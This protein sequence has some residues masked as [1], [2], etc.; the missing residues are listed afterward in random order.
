MAKRQEDT[1]FDVRVLDT[2]SAHL[3][4]N[5]WTLAVA[6]SVTSG[7]LQLAFSQTEGATDFF[8]GGVTA[9]HPGIKCRLLDM[10]PVVGGQHFCVNEQAAQSM[11][12]G[13]HQLFPCTFS[14]AITGFASTI[15]EDQDAPYAYYAISMHR[16]LLKTGK[17]KTEE[18]GVFSVQKEFTQSL[19]SLFAD[20]L[21]NLTY[22]DKET[23][24]DRGTDQT[25]RNP[26]L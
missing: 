6:E 10:D 18:K 12:L 2:I 25:V 7:A 4:K 1:L 14:L 20:Q 15:P 19:L 9:Y 11:C 26:D 22:P 5:S 24:D 13:V 17:L 16:K 21:R 8:L 23:H 3:Q